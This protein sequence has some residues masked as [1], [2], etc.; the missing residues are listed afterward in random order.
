MLVIRMQRMGRKRQPS[1][2]LIIQDKTRSPQSKHIEIVG[3]YN[4]RTKEKG[5]KE[6]R[7]NY[8]L[9]QGALPTDT[10]NNLLVDAGLIQGEKRRT[11]TLSGARKAQIAEAAKKAEE[12]QKETPPATEEA[13]AAAEESQ[14]SEGV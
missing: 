14:P 7:I 13:P 4:P 12:A 8:W 10:V 9:G 3:F 5:L 1:F 11:V 2:R 6:D